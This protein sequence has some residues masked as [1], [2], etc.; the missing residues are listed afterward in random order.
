MERHSPSWFPLLVL[1]KVRHH[2]SSHPTHSSE[3]LSLPFLVVSSTSHFLDCTVA[4]LPIKYSGGV[5]VWLLGLHYKIQ[6]SLLFADWNTLWSPEL[7]R[8]QFSTTKYCHGMRKP[9]QPLAISTNSSHHLTAISGETLNWNIP[10]GVWPTQNVRYGCFKPGS[11]MS[12]C[13]ATVIIRIGSY[14]KG[15]LLCRQNLVQ[16]YFYK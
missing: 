1:S 2:T 8:K 15:C 13:S 5:T 11:F 6:F 10:E 3:K 14:G 7:A 12:I 4:L 9:N 16:T